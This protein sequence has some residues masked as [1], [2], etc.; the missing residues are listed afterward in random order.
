MHALP[1]IIV[2]RFCISSAYELYAMW[3]A[4]SNRLIPPITRQ[5]PSYSQAKHQ[6][7]LR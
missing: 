6:R 1:A 4:H 3:A 2:G 7:I 5:E